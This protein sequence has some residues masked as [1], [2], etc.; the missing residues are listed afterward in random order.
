VVGDSVIVT[1]HDREGVITTF[2]F[3]LKDSLTVLPTTRASK[4]P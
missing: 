4:R 2:P 1:I 3:V